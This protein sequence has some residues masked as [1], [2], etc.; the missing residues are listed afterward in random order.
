M[1]RLSKAH[2]N[3]KKKI[4]VYL[5]TKKDMNKFLINK[6]NDWDKIDKLQIYNYIELFYKKFCTQR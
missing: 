3:N 6:T 4:K 1:H 2:L 5:F